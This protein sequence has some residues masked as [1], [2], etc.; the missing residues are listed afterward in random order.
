MES[1]IK[2]WIVLTAD[3]SGFPIAHHL[4]QE[5]HKV[6]VGQVQDKSELKNGDEEKPEDK[7]KRLAQFEGIVKKV[8]A[9]KLVK[10]LK[11]MANKDEFFIFVDRNNLWA[12]SEEF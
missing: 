3:G 2:Q 1:P 7:K 12:Y 10:A 11:T 6:W 5:G 9:K 4:L 8:P